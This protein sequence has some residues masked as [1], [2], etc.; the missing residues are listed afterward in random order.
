N[1]RGSATSPR[2]SDQYLVSAEF[3]T[4][5]SDR[6]D[7]TA[8]ATYSE[9]DR[10]F[11]GTDTFGDLLQNALSGFGGPNCAFSSAASRQGLTATQLAALAG[12][13]G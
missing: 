6:L 1:E 10:V 11:Y 9:Y 5:L 8:S 12:T 3:R 2:I 7:L 4:E 13:N